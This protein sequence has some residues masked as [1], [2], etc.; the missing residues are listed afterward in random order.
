MTGSNRLAIL[1]LALFFV[2]GV[3]LLLGVDVEKGRL[4]AES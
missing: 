2:V 3:A 1:A 4:Q